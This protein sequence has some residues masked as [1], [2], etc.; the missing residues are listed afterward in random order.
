MW[1]ILQ[2]PNWKIKIKL[3]IKIDLIL[4][5]ENFSTIISSDLLPLL[6]LGLVPVAA[7]SGCAGIEEEGSSFR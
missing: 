3:K 4:K 7:T 2:G 5:P 6:D 1:F